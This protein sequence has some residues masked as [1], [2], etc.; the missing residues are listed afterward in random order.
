MTDRP[1]PPT[2]GAPWKPLPRALLLLVAF[3]ALVELALQAADAGYLGDASLRTRVYIAGAFWSPLLYGSEPL[4]AVQPVTMFLSHALLHGSFFHMAMNMT[5]F[6]ALGRFASDRYGAGVVLP[7]FFLGA[8]GGGAVFGLLT[9][10]AIPMVGASG[11]IFAFIGVW[12]VW[13][14]RRHRA[15][16]VSVRPVATRVVVLTGIN[17]VFFLGLGGMLAWEAHL[18]GFLAGLVCGHLLEARR[19]RFDRTIRTQARRTR[20]ARDRADYEARDD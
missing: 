2:P 16:R 18:G 11:A 20:L 15:A 9:S 4:Y 1:L 7:V 19:A 5:V 8:L 17:L 12:I 6:L 3:M 10:E 14:W 13:D